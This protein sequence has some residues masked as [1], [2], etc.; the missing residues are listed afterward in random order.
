M[1]RTAK[2]NTTSSADTE[3]KDPEK[4]TLT[5]RYG[6]T[7]EVPANRLT[8]EHTIRF[9]LDGKW[10]VI[11]PITCPIIPCHFDPRW[12]AWQPILDD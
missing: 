9:G 12:V 7:W 5:D 4:V 6:R 8:V 10:T 1:R 3:K 2:K 11:H